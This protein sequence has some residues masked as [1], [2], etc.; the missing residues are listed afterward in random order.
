MKYINWVLKMPSI[1][2][3]SPSLVRHATAPAPEN[4]PGLLHTPIGLALLELQGSFN[5]PIPPSAS[6]ADLYDAKASEKGEAGA[7]RLGRLVFPDYDNERDGDREGPWMKRVVMLVGHQK[8]RGEIKKLPKPLAV[9]KKQRVPKPE[10]ATE[11]V[12]EGVETNSGYN[13]NEL[14]IVELIKYKMVFTSRPEP[15]GADEEL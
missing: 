4:L 14:E 13:N 3:H 7:T 5:Y 12:M 10:A 11:D 9:V 1:N 8:L 6:S 2:L 15:V